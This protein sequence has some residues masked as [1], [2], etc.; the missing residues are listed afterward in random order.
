MRR[1]LIHRWIAVVVVLALVGSLSFVFVR[2]VH[3]HNEPSAQAHAAMTFF[4]SK[5]LTRPQAAGIVGNL[6][7]ESRVNPTAVQANGPGQGVAQWS[8]DQRWNDVLAYAYSTNR[9]VWAL[10]VQLEFIWYDLNSTYASTLTALRKTTTVED[11]T[12]VFE[13]QYLRAGRPNMPRRFAMAR[14]L[15]A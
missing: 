10:L 14:Q 5:G 4:I 2:A 13:H 3:K 1:V 11:A 6:M 9:S 12:L 8:L 7:Q 15:A